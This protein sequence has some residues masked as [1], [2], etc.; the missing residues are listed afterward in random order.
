MK[1]PS[2]VIFCLFLFGSI[3]SFFGDAGLVIGNILG[4]IT[5]LGL[6]PDERILLAPNSTSSNGLITGLGLSSDESGAKKESK[7]VN[8]RMQEKFLDSYTTES[9]QK[10]LAQRRSGRSLILISLALAMIS[11]FL[12]W[13]K[14]F[15]F[16]KTGID[17]QLV[18][19]IAFWMYPVIASFFLL[20]INRKVI[21][22]II[23]LNILVSLGL[24][25]YIAN[26]AVFFGLISVSVG[27]G[28]WLYL[29]SVILLWYGS[30]R[31]KCLAVHK[32]LL[33]YQ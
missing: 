6:S 16:S 32:S 3:G 26:K 29:I 20:P 25:Y 4:L 18:F 7:P 23:R 15:K 9:D 12:G 22:W 2:F 5:G 13:E 19:I 31:Y 1:N 11:M 27:V 21:K 14:V 24:I 30:S 33:L 10:V 8:N 17:L 28:V